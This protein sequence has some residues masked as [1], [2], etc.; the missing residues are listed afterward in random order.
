MPVKMEDFVRAE[1]GVG[2]MAG[3]IRLKASVI[4]PNG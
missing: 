1:F 4:G 3:K 2:G